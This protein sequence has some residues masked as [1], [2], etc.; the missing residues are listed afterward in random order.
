MELVVAFEVGGGVE[1]CGV[2]GEGGDFVRIAGDDASGIGD[3]EG[4]RVGGCGSDGALDVVERGLDVAGAT[5]GVEEDAG[6]GNAGEAFVEGMAGGGVGCL[7]KAGGKRCSGARGSKHGEV[8]G[9]ETD[10]GLVDAEVHDAAG[11]EVG[12]FGDGVGDGGG[13]AFGGEHLLEG[14]LDVVGERAGIRGYAA[15]EGDL[16]VDA[17]GEFF[18]G[19]PDEVFEAGGEELVEGDGV[20]VDDDG[21][22]AG[23]VAVI[24]GGVGEEAGVEEAL[25]GVGEGVVA[26]GLAGLEAGDGE[27]LGGG[28]GV[29]VPERD[30]GNGVLGVEVR[31]AAKGARR[32]RA[33]RTRWGRKEGLR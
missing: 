30:A 8:Q 10:E 24:D 2:P 19:K 21:A 32:R 25:G 14:G 5:E 22:G 31:G 16:R 17:G 33:A 1:G 12:G 11:L 15:V 7:L 6:E 28:V 23:G 9:A 20:D 26:E 18:G 27:E 4:V 13:D 3:D 29:G